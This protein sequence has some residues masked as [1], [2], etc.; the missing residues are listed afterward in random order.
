MTD[1]I[2]NSNDDISVDT[3]R[4]SVLPVLKQFGLYDRDDYK[5]EL[6]INKRG[7]APLA[8]GEVYLTVPNPKKL[9]PCLALGKQF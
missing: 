9:R 4:L 8:G 7:S 3:Y 2:T 1:C 6:K 5:F